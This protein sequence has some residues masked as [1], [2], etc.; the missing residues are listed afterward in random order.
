MF[1]KC[2]KIHAELPLDSANQ[3]CN[4][5]DAPLVN[6]NQLK[7]NFNCT[8]LLKRKSIF[9]DLDVKMSG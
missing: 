1:V 9:V 8:V 3:M 5:S 7:M 6:L 2:S 4:I